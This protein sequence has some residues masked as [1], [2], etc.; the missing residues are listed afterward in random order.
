MYTLCG[1]HWKNLSK[2]DVGN[3]LSRTWVAEQNVG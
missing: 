1:T 3:L 2:D